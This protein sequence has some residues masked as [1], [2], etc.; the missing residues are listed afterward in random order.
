MK[1]YKTVSGNGESEFIEKKSRFISFVYPVTTEKDAVSYIEKARKQFYD[2]TH[3]VYAYK[4]RENNIARFSD[5]GEPQGTAGIPVLDVINKSGIEDVLIIVVRYFG[6][7]LLGAGGLVRAYSKSASLGVENAV[8]C[9]MT[10]C[11]VFEIKCPYNLLS[12]VQYILDNHLAYKIDI[13]YM[14]DITL[15]YYIEQTKFEN[16]KN[17]LFDKTN[18]CI[19]AEI[20]ATEFHKIM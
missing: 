7:T 3:V 12:Q 10:P 13:F 2:S 17:D 1:I 9:T 11:S 20:T 8:V 4:L 6:G 16:L 15:K 19:I 18:G 14:Q 5:D